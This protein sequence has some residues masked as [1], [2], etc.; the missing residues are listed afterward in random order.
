MKTQKKVSRRSILRATGL[1]IGAGIAARLSALETEAAAPK[2]LNN[3][4]LLDPQYR[5][6]I[7]NTYSP[8]PK[9]YA[10]NILRFP[11]S[12]FP[13][14]IQSIAWGGAAY[15][16][17]RG[18]AEWGSGP[19]DNE[20]G[21]AGVLHQISAH[22]HQ[23]GLRNASTAGNNAYALPTARATSGAKLYYFYNEPDA[24]TEFPNHFLTPV[25]VPTQEVA[26]NLD[27]IATTCVQTFFENLGGNSNTRRIRGAA[28]AKLYLKLK[29][30]VQTTGTYSSTN[31]FLPPSSSNAFLGSAYSGDIGNRTF[32]Q[33]FFQYVHAGI[34]GTCA[35]VGIAPSQLGALHTHLYNTVYAGITDPLA[36]IAGGAIAIRAGVEWYRATYLS[37][38]NLPL[39]YILSETGP[40]WNITYNEKGKNLWF[41]G[42]NTMA[43]MLAYYNTWWR[44]LSRNAATELQLAPGKNVYAMQEEPDV[45]PFI[46][47]RTSSTSVNDGKG[48]DTNARVQGYFSWG[49]ST[50]P[51][52]ATKRTTSFVTAEVL[53]VGSVPAPIEAN[54]LGD[55]NIYRTRWTLC[56]GSFGSTLTHQAG[57]YP[58]PDNRVFWW[59]PMTAVLSTW[60]EVGGLA[61]NTT[62]NWT[63]GGWN[64]DG[65]TSGYKGYF[66]V[67]LAPGWSTVYVP[68]AKTTGGTPTSGSDIR[69]QFHWLQIGNPAFNGNPV[70][71]GE[72]HLHN[73]VFPDVQVFPGSTTPGQYPNS[74]TVQPAMICP[75][76]VYNGSGATVTAAQLHVQ[77]ASAAGN[78]QGISVCQPVVR[79]G[80]TCTWFDNQ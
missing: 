18:Y 17:F 78:D 13:V 36:P 27:P 61:G 71:A 19:V 58:A 68:I 11:Q 72:L 47:K 3:P 41:V 4:M 29:Y 10:Q 20:V 67:N 34:G 77:R 64:Y 79:S 44:W 22:N 73:S 42:Y 75:L 31:L 49:S 38:G 33:E 52:S 80:I 46:V 24:Y 28:L 43:K 76:L 48:L 21:S 35:Q 56:P 70:F 12:N 60:A 6:G 40:V 45:D 7:A 39:D 25:P 2:T 32:W 15:E 5:I 53:A 37:N 14:Y 16:N 57:A 50:K 59:S 1:M 62:G 65:A 69:Y 9:W 54:S 26:F 66:L 23:F 74:Q 51:G 55:V 63:N 30:E 8:N